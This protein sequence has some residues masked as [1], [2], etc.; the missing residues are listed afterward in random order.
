MFRLT[1]TINVIMGIESAALE[2]VSRFVH[3]FAFVE[4]KF[5][6]A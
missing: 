3:G 2:T 4:V 6:K 1:V 5:Q